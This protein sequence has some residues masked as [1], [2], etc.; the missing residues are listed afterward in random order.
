MVR[1]L[2]RQV[3]VDRPGET[4]TAD[5]ERADNTLRTQRGAC[6]KN[7]SPGND[8]CHT[9]GNTAIEV[10]L[11]G[12]PRQQRREHAFEV[13][14]ERGRGRVG[15]AQAEHEEERPD[16]SARENCAEKPGHLET[17]RRSDFRLGSHRDAN[18][19]QHQQAKPG[20]H[21]EEAGKKQ[22][23]RSADKLLRQRRAETEQDRRSKRGTH[24][25]IYSH[26]ATSTILSEQATE[27]RSVPKLSRDFIA[28]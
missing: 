1:D 24:I 16:R 12:K 19:Q 2:A 7:D 5:G 17:A 26:A 27:F 13:Q 15:P 3:V 25:A 21:I 18:P 6:G 11:E 9:P 20:A 22:W 4:R 8:G 28:Q 14:D 23:R 10:L